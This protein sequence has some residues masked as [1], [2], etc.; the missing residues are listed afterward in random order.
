VATR[1]GVFGR[2]PRAA[3]D[4]TNTIVALI[5]EANAQED[6][7]FVDAWKN[8]G[9]VDGKGVNDSRLLA[10]MKK[11]RDDL[12][13]SDPN[14]DQWNNNYI[15]YDFSIN[16]SKMVLKNDQGKVSDTA[17]AQFYTK[18]AGRSDVQQDSE[19]YRSLLDRA[20]KW[21]ASAK[22][23]HAG[24]GARAAAKAHADWANGF[25]K[26]H[27]QGAE[28]ATSQLLLIA[29]EYNAAPATAQT[30]DE[31]D[32]NSVGY[33]KFLDII[34][35]GK[36]D[37]PIVQ[38]AIDEMNRKIKETNPNWTYSRQ[39]L[40][41][42]LNRATNGLKTLHNNA[43]SDTERKN[44]DK[45][46]AYLKYENA[47]IQQAKANQRI[48]IA[49]DNFVTALGSCNGDPYCARGATQDYLHALQRD[50]KNVVA[51]QGVL[52]ADT[53]SIKS[54]SALQ[55]TIEQ[56]TAGLAGKDVKPPAAVA[57]QTGALPSPNKAGINPADEPTI[58]DAAASNST[59][60]GFLA[61]TLNAINGDMTKLDGG[62]W[63]STEPLTTG[64][65]GSGDLVLDGHGQPVFQYH[66]HDAGEPTPVGAIAVPGTTTMSDPTRTVIGPDGKP[67]P[68]AVTP[69]VYV[70]PVPPNLA[71]VDANG[72]KVDPKAVGDIHLTIGTQATG[73]PWVE[74][75]GVKGPDGVART[76][77]RTG[78]G[79]TLTPFLF[80][81]QPPVDVGHATNAAGQVIVPITVGKDAQG[82]PL[83]SA[84]IADI[85]AGVTKS[86]TA[87]P[88]GAHVLG[89]YTSAGATQTSLAVGDLFHKNDP[90]ASQKADS[91]MHSLELSLAFMPFNDP[92]RAGVLQDINQLRSRVNMYKTGTADN[93][94]ATT[95]AQ[96]NAYD[97]KTQAYQD[98]LS[99]AGVTPNS[100]GRDEFN[101]RVGV[102]AG[103]DAADARIAAR[104]S[105]ATN[106]GG[107][108]GYGALMFGNTPADYS[109]DK[110]ALSQSRQDVLNPTISVSSIKVPGMPALM[111]PPST[112]NGPGMTDVFGNPLFPA[113]PKPF[114]APGA[115]GPFASLAAPP[116]AAPVTPPVVPPPA[117][118]PPL[119]GPPLPSSP[120]S[121]PQSNPSQTNAPWLLGAPATPPPVPYSPYGGTR[122][123]TG[124]RGGA[125]PR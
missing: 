91:Y 101:R 59:P 37:D 41:D 84:N 76:L 108:G 119:P 63:M 2:I 42:L 28:T 38:S 17:M 10:H 53:V 78:D 52:N 85:A 88:S 58:F 45:H 77:Y 83:A 13:P 50:V 87:L 43:T 66:V 36:S 100:V 96:D 40:N 39:N 46:T 24:S 89:T 48:Q 70:I 35:N 81:E 74:L 25:F 125:T 104:P 107:F 18:W 112:A 109:S 99:K 31:I 72:N 12:D 95:Y 73:T 1:R 23:K 94:I 57:G 44:Y 97:P 3:P 121:G 62:G 98:Q 30:L 5:R 11:R 71:Y 20:A 82:N 113:Q 51:G 93:V 69:P 116:K 111:Q 65:N 90:L 123:S 56:L 102:L 49:S 22:A 75:H 16:E 29:K 64:A 21:N 8:G 117:A 92:E 32:P 6:Q 124:G 4:L 80:H 68:H 19:F 79:S 122:P 55:A 115:P 105:V 120:T 33:A 106:S 26:S 27:V 86:R 61:N 47:R 103:I 110:N 7:N 118:T 9:K 60:N 34:D 15:Q 67:V 114:L 14:W 54:A